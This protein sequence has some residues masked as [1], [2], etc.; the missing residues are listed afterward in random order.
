MT[1]EQAKEKILLSSRYTRNQA[2]I[3]L[4]QTI[5]KIFDYFEQRIAEL[6]EMI[7]W[8]ENYSNQSLC[9]YYNRNES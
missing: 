2:D 1:R 8:M 4:F 5:D 6:E 7:D 3:L 9:D